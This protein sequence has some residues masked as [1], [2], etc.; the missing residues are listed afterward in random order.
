MTSEQ[1]K[2]NGN[3]ANSSRRN[4]I[5]G[6]VMATSALALIQIFC[7]FDRCTPTVMDNN[8]G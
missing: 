3:A 2:K 1:K 4:F 6:S 5:K 8:M 7:F